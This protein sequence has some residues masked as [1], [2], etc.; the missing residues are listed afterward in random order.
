M[1]NK[2]I[3]IFFNLETKSY[4]SRCL[5]N[6]FY[7]L[8]HFVKPS[9]EI[10]LINRENKDLSL[11]IFTSELSQVTLS[12]RLMSALKSWSEITEWHSLKSPIPSSLFTTPH[13]VDILLFCV[14]Y[15]KSTNKKF[16]STVSLPLNLAPDACMWENLENKPTPFRVNFLE[17]ENGVVCFPEKR[18]V[19]AG[20]RIT[21]KPI[22]FPR[23]LGQAFP[24]S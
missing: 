15:R 16:T 10:R 5:W 7:N 9:K 14:N 23:D 6:E 20:Q 24:L 2:Y 19:F 22:Y 18:T 12:Y 8:V 4:D 13:S 21:D 3:K 11:Q 1:S 17:S